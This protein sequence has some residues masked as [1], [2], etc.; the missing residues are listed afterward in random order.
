MVEAGAN[1]V[2]EDVIVQALEAGHAAIKSIVAVIDEMAAE[3]GKAKV[4]VAEKA[5]DPALVQRGRGEDVRPARRG[6]AHQGQARQLRPG[7]RGHRRYLAR[8]H[9]GG[10]REEGGGEEGHQGTEGEGAARR[11]PRSRRSAST[12]ARST[13][14]ARSGPRSAWSPGRTARRSSRAAR[15]RRSCPRRWAPPTISRRSRRSTARSTSGSC[16]TTTSRPSR[17]ARWRSCG[18][19]AAARSV[20]ARLPSARWRR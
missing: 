5:I 3:I 19:P 4:P 12:A 15:P 10:G 9:R 16:C 8:L 2:G 7:R 13:R 17:S 1:E 20:T 18:A 11:D 6:D 14:S